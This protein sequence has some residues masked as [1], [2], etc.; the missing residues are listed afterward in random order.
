MNPEEMAARQAMMA[1]L[2]GNPQPLMS[3]TGPLAGVQTPPP[4][5]PPVVP[6]DNIGTETRKASPHEKLIKS[7]L[8]ATSNAYNP[9]VQGISKV[10]LAK[11]IPYLGGQ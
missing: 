2:A 7:L 5:P 4:A 8:P 9:D 10:L 3:Q 11:L 1:R 6:Q